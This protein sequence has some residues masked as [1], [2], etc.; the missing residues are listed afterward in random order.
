MSEPD[1]VIPL[2]YLKPVKNEY[3]TEALGREVWEEKEYVEIIVPGDRNAVVHERVKQA[4]KDRWP[5][6][7]LAFT[8]SRETPV[9]GT[10]LEEWP[11]VN[12][13]MVMELKSSHVRTVEQ[14]AGLSDGQLSKTVSMGG[15]ELRRKAQLFVEG[16]SESDARI[17]DLEAKLAALTAAMEAKSEPVAEAAE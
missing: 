3:Q 12:S 8:Q 11:V 2:F 17:A 10:P 7:Y 6:Q 1:N 5:R 9:D 14:L 15:F 16:K 4:H 13:A